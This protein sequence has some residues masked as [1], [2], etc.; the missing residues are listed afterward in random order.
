VALGEVDARLGGLE[1]LLY[2][3]QGNGA[4]ICVSAVRSDPV[5]CGYG[6]AT[7]ADLWKL[8]CDTLVRYDVTHERQV[9]IGEDAFL[10]IYGGVTA[11]VAWVTRGQLATASVTCLACDQSWA[12][13]AARSTAVLLNRLLSTRLP[14]A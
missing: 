4:L 1:I 7:P 8:A 12:V 14:D 9:G 3:F 6:D 13:G 10:A 5:A 11:Q 2:V